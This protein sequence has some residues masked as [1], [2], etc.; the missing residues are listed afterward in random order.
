MQGN[1]ISDTKTCYVFGDINFRN[2]K[3]KVKD[4]LL[5]LVISKRFDY[6]DAM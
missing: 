3:F 4:V 6:E 5:F 1:T 2:W